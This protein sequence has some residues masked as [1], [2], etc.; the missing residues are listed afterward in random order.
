LIMVLVGAEVTVV[1]LHE[2][3]ESP[4]IDG[5]GMERSVEGRRDEEL[6]GGLDAN[7]L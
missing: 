4:F 5:V 3:M 1:C 2:N 7:L 6:F